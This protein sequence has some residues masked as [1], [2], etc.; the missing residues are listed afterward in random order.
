MDTLK[1]INYDKF[2]CSADKCKF[3]CCSGWDINIDD[4]TY[5]KWENDDSARYIINNIILKEFDDQKGYCV[6]KQTSAHCPFLDTRG[7]CEIVK[8][9]GENYL[10]STCYAF[11]RIENVFDDVKEIS[12]SCACPEVVEIIAQ[13]NKPIEF[14]DSIEESENIILKIR[15]TLIKIISFENID[16]EY[17]ILIGYEMLIKLLDTE[18]LTYEFVLKVLDQYNEITYAKDIVSD[19]KAAKFDILESIKE[20]NSFFLDITENYKDVAVLKDVLNPL[21]K[22]ANVVNLEDLANNWTNFKKLY[23]KEELLL[24]NCIISKI[25]SNCTSDDVEE[26]TNAMQMIIL[27]YLLTR[28][29]SFLKYSMSENREINV[30]DIKDYIVIFSRVIGN[31]TDAVVDFLEESFDDYILEIGYLSFISLY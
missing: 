11:P 29:A 15:E 19:Y 1:V 22:F 9:H 31:N 10:S 3:T 7:L 12:L 24:Q 28:Y 18:D 14:E 8:S 27:D 25:T 13:S 30:S 17:K 5:K 20:F 21:D 6:D 16:L 2:K 26:I 4:M 23:Y